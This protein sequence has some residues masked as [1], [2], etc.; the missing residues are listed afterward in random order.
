MAGHR[1]GKVDGRRIVSHVLGGECGAA[2]DRPCGA[3]HQHAVHD[4]RITDSHVAQ[5]DLVFRA[6]GGDERDAVGAGRNGLAGG[7][8]GEGDQ[9]RVV[10][11][12]A[13]NPAFRHG[14]R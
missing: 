12:D 2:R 3:A 6:H 4:D 14:R 13:E 5:H 1:R 10:R 9:D 7:E 11:V 8:V